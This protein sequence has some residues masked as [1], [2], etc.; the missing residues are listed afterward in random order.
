M[1]AS[2]RQSAS[3]HT[4]PRTGDAGGLEDVERNV[5]AVIGE[6]WRIAR[7]RWHRLRLG[8]LESAY[9]ALFMAW[10]A[11]VAVVASVVAAVLLVVGAA[12]GVAALADGRA[13]VG[14]LVVGGLVLGGSALALGAARAR[15]RRSFLASLRSR[16]EPELEQQRGAD[17]PGAERSTP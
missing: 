13:W 17:S 6:L 5:S 2:D 16:L 9:S 14:R 15:M 4:E 1:I 7:I 11:L 3:G 8:T 12:G 10:A